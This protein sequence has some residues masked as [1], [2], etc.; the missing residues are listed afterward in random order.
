MSD[1]DKD[2]NS[3]NMIEREPEP[4]KDFSLV[5]V[6]EIPRQSKHRG[7]VGTHF[8]TLLHLVLT[9]AEK[10]GYGH[11]CSWQSHGRCF[12]VSNRDK[13]VS[14]VMP[15][16]F[17]QSQ[18]A[19]FQRQLNLY[20]FRRLSQRSPDH[21]SYY[22]EMF[23][24]TRADLCQG[25]LRAKEKDLRATKAAREEP[26]FR[27]MPPM[28]P[29]TEEDIGTTESILMQQ[30]TAAKEGQEMNALVE[31]NFNLSKPQGDPLAHLFNT[32]AMQGIHSNDSWMD[33]RPI[34]P[35]LSGGDK[36]S[37]VPRGEASFQSY[38][39]PKP[40]PMPLPYFLTGGGPEV[41]GP[42]MNIPPPTPP[43]EKSTSSVSYHQQQEHHSDIIRKVSNEKISEKRPFVAEK[44]NSGE[45]SA[46][47]QAEEE[48]YS[49]KWLAAVES[50]QDE[51]E[52]MVHF[53]EDVDLD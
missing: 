39:L 32:I 17:R 5:S 46:K 40:D 4:F 41:Y 43:V 9:R 2:P 45:R 26:D 14:E 11:I 8:P 25:I 50:M 12:S 13:F 37:P 22:H 24:R 19:S 29:V 31:D 36:E 53:L 52:G 42:V 6:D 35:F 7:G 1:E 10:D 15:S 16:Y 3:D 44:C 48:S 47:R 38:A 20:G 30:K 27:K 18:Y 23:L 49:P 21:G 34:A 51:V 33:P 28:P